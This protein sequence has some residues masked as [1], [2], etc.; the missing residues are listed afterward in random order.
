MNDIGRKVF[1]PELGVF[2]T[3]VKQDRN[4]RVEEIQLSSSIY[5]RNAIN[6]SPIPTII[7]VVDLTVIVIKGLWDLWP[8]IREI[9]K[10][11]KGK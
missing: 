3:V 1:I 7:L 4:G 9:I 5:K 10:I 2:G 6:E 11:I 8:V